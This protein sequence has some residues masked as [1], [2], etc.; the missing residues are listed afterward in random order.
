[1]NDA[2]LYQITPDQI[3]ELREVVVKMS[4]VFEGHE[5]DVVMVALNTIVVSTIMSHVPE[6][7]QRYSAQ[8]FMNTFMITMANSGVNLYPDKEYIN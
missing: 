3:D 6:A 8:T 5:L 7:Y 4:D 2:N 1:M